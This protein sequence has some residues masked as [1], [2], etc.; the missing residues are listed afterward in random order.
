MY[1]LI[2]FVTKQR[3]YPTDLIFTGNTSPWEVCIDL[4]MVKKTLLRKEFKAAAPHLTKYLPFLPFANSPMLLRWQETPTPLIKSKFIGPKLGIDLYFKIEG[5][6]PTGSFKDR[7]SAIEMTIA[8]Q[9]HAKKVIVAS[10]GNMAASCACYAAL[11]ELPCLVLIPKGVPVAKLAQVLAYGGE[12]QEVDGTYSDAAQLARTIA[13][14]NSFY[15]AGDYAFRVEGQKTAIFE[16]LD[17]L[18]FRLPDQ[19]ILPIGCGTNLAAY[20]KGL[21]EYHSLGLITRFPQL[22]GVQAKGANSVVRSFRKGLTTVKSLKTTRTLAS[23]IAV[24]TPIDGMKALEA[25]HQTQG[26]ALDVSDTAI[27]QA[28]HLLSTR[29][30]LFVEAASAAT[31]ASLFKLHQSG[32]LKGKVVCILTGDGLKDINVTLKNKIAKALRKS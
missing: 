24:G 5:Q 3:V 25:L 6:N 30:S 22:V 10:T 7:G 27:L 23:A 31:V 16:L 4:K 12:I 21:R 18:H 8:K 20:Y 17:Q 29:E 28:H 2:D 26:V 13:Q 14:K 1:H 15:L 32:T 9:H 19:I 11:A